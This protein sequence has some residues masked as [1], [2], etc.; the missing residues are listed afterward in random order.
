MRITIVLCVCLLLAGCANPGLNRAVIRDA[1]NNQLLAAEYPS[2][3]TVK[4][5]GPAG[6]IE[7]FAPAPKP[8][9]AEDMVKGMSAALTP[10]MPIMMI[11]AMDND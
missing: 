7:V 5:D 3:S 2:G 1:D 6:K 11:K 8:S 4:Y 10:L 9:F